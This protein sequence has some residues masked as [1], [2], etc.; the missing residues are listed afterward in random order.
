MAQKRDWIQR[1]AEN[2]ELTETL[3]GVPIV[4]LAGD[5]RVLIEC[6]RGITEYSSGLIRVRVRYGSIRILG[7]GLEIGE[8]TRERLVIVGR[9]DGIQICREGG[10]R[11]A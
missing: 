11:G 5:K 3:P 4:E 10:Y 6:H 1:L 2:S 9:I 7:C 8:M